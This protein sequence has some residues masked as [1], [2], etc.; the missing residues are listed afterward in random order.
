MFTFEIA[1]H[2][3]LCSSVTSTDLILG[4]IDDHLQ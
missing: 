3:K 4:D 2:V 1:E